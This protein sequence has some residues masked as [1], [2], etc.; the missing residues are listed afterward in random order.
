MSRK[1]TAAS[2]AHSSST[3]L[4]P[5][6]DPA[7]YP[8]VDRISD[9]P[10]LPEP[11]KPEA[12]RPVEADG[13]P[14]SKFGW[15]FREVVAETAGLATDEVDLGLVRQAEALNADTHHNLAALSA[16]Q[17]KRT[18]HGVLRYVRVRVNT[19][20]VAPYLLNGRALRRMGPEMRGSAGRIV[21]RATDHP[22]LPL[23]TMS[24]DS[25]ETVLEVIGAQRRLLGLESYT[26]TGQNQAK[27]DRVDSIVQFGVLEQ[28][29][30]VFV[31]VTSETGSAWTA[32]AAEGAQR[33]FSSHV[34]MD[35]LASRSVA[36]LGSEHWFAGEPALRDLTA[37]DLSRLADELR[38]PSSAAAG[39][40]PGR[41]VKAW[42][43]TTATTTPAAVA[44]QLLRTMEINLIIAVEP[45]SVVTED[46]DNPVSST[47]AE[48]IRSYHV[49]GKA[50]D[51]WQDA[52]VQGLIAIGAIDELLADGRVAPTDRS[53]WL[54]ETL[55]AWS[56]GSGP[57]R[58]VSV[59]RLVATLTAQHGVPAAGGAGADSLL[60]VNRHL[61]LNGQQ[62]RSDNRAKAAAAQAIIALDAN[63][64]GRENTISAAIFGT[65]RATWFWK[66]DEHPGGRWPALLESP[67]GEITE[68]A[69]AEAKASDS[70]DSCGPAQRALAALGGIALMVNPGLV[71]E[72][73]SLTRTARGGGGQRA[74]GKVSASDPNVL[75]AAMVQDD[76]GID[77][78][79]DAVVALT[80]NAEPTVPIDRQD[81]HVLDEFY[82]RKMWLGETTRT[83]DAN[84][85]V[86]FARL[87]NDLTGS[88]A[89]GSAQSDYLREALPGDLLGLEREDDDD[90]ELWDEAVYERIGVTEQTADEALPALQ[91]LVEFFTTGKAY[92]KAAARA[93]K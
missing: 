3:V 33:L 8:P 6:K 16:V 89:A 87:V 82:L 60:T 75:L 14:L 76:R 28:P 90:P 24:V 48:M 86:E 64:T 43:E 10:L 66:T 4:S 81:S 91:K 84:P 21:T 80:A 2:T 49:P 57:N 7:L 78:L 39:Y 32:Q 47:L 22:T 72:D 36:A 70:A 27:R 56:E 30:V 46:E 38:F 50:K 19:P 26:S 53:N 55:P 12:G 5:L 23:P 83:K 93:S 15:R 34:G 62:V 13:K 79:H 61:K 63:M 85:L 88:I 59:T 51:Q 17:A 41:D 9:R 11:F 69:R 67:I 1:N 35:Q 25:P 42:L 52:D 37:Q 20:L 45:D 44:F 40:F 73:E 74:A 18:E 68:K 77:Q 71:E 65:F 54:A 29:D 58:L 92:A 31:Q